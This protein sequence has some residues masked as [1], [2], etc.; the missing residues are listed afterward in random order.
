MGGAD[1]TYGAGARDGRRAG[2]R[3]SACLGASVL[4]CLACGAPAWASPSAPGTDPALDP[5]AHG[6]AL[7]GPEAAQPERLMPT[8]PLG[9]TDDRPLGPARTATPAPAGGAAAARPRAVWS[10]VWSLVLVIGTIAAVALGW[11]W[12]ARRSPSLS[13]YG[14]SRAP[15]GLVELLGRYPLA[16]GSGL[17]LLRVHNRVLLVSQGSGVSASGSCALA[18][19]DDPAEVAGILALVREHDA[20]AN[21]R[22]FVKQ[23][24]RAERGDVESAAVRPTLLGVSGLSRGLRALR[25]GVRGVVALEEAAS[26][27]GRS[28][29]GKRA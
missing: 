19:F 1:R 3:A 6:A 24:E 28:A 29:G 4:A 25:E 5:A 14:P 20:R 26:D 17:V 27:G 2:A 13:M 15:A 18:S 12:L 21:P 7:N 23:L 10:T 11:R 8:R 9:F 16:R 22:S